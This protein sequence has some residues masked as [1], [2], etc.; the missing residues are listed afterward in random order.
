MFPDTV[1]GPVMYAALPAK[2]IHIFGE[3]HH[4]NGTR[5]T[6]VTQA[7]FDFAAKHKSKRVAY[8]IEANYK[9]LNLY[10]AGIP[11]SSPL[12]L[13]AKQIRDSPL[14]I[15]ENVDI[16]MADVRYAPP[17]NL[18][19]ATIDF[20]SY[21]SCFIN[22]QSNNY[23]FVNKYRAEFK[24]VK[25]VEKSL[26]TAMKSRRSCIHFMMSLIDPNLA[27]P[28]WLTE[29]A[30]PDNDLKAMMQKIQ[31][32]YPGFGQKLRDIIGKELDRVVMHQTKFS[33]AMDVANRNRRT[34]S[35]RLVADKSAFFR[36]FLV[37]LQSVF[38]DA[39]AFGMIVQASQTHDDVVYLAGVNHAQT[40]AGFL[41][42]G[43]MVH[44]IAPDGN[45]DL[46]AAGL[47]R[48]HPEAMPGLSP[49][50]LL[51]KFMGEAR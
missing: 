44:A 48:G 51:D 43:A 32:S 25:Q 45:L 9:S 22:G 31:T 1:A 36:A 13:L 5:G 26:L 14:T 23:D 24:K 19:Q 16:W 41:P 12:K 18:L 34:A 6:P 20:E 8:V 49:N 39:Y 47:S 7:L 40:V 21:A 46:S 11:P 4:V 3:L 2:G 28:Q 29:A 50:A 38:M 37:V 33:A 30:G 15:P 17:F 27:A 10:V 42:A 35:Q